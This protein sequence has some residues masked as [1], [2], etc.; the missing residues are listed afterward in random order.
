MSQPNVQF[1]GK[2]DLG[3]D[4]HEYE[5]FFLLFYSVWFHLEGTDTKI[6]Q[7]NACPE[8]F[9]SFWIPYI[10]YCSSGVQFPP[11]WFSH[12]HVEAAFS[13]PHCQGS[14]LMD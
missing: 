4:R 12:R 2:A 13:A 8:I 9:T 10:R 7:A 11:I 6:T 3:I 5:A 14:L 1:D